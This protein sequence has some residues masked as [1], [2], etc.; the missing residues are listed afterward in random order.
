MEENAKMFFRKYGSTFDSWDMDKF[1]S[2]FHEPFISIRG[3]GKSV[4]M[5]TK[6]DAKIFFTRVLNTWKRDG[7]H[8]FQTK[9]YE[10]INLGE[11]SILVTFTWQ[12]MNKENVIIRQWRQSYNLVKYNNQWKIIMSTFHINK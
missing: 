10:I 12:M 4:I 9:D 2:F 7:Y 5:N 6:R 8:K 3:D 11:Q 1:S